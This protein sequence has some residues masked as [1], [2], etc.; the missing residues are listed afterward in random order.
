MKDSSQAILM[1]KPKY[2]AGSMPLL[3]RSL[4]FLDRVQAGGHLPSEDALMSLISY[5]RVFNEHPCWLKV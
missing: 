3:L 5:I 1:S 4:Q 2:I